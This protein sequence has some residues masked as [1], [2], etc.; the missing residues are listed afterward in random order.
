MP[1]FERGAV[2]RVPFPYSDG[3]SGQHRPALVIATVADGF[4]LWVLMITSASN[5]PWPGDVTI[6]DAAACGLPAPSVIRCA[7]I[8]TIEAGRAEV[9]GQITDPVLAEVA[10]RVNALLADGG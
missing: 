8:A 3:A 2:V 1:G 5:R 6:P 7:K 4:L 10:G 9:R